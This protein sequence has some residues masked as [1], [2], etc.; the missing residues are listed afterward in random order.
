MIE[1]IEQLG[2]SAREQI[3]QAQSSD[4]LEELR[5]RYLGRRAE[6]PQMLRGIPALEPQERA[7]VGAAA[8]GV[9]RALEE[10]IEERERL[11]QERELDQ[12]LLAASRRQ[13]V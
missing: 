7:R 11:L 9:R 5:V 3:A 8:N 13:D 12:E 2:A 6:L 4:A 10:Q 1:R